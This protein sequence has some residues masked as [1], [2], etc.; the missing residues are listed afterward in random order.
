M[1]DINIGTT[2]TIQIDKASLQNL[3]LGLAAVMVGTVLFYFLVKKF[4]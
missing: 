4:V 1:N 2:V 3:L